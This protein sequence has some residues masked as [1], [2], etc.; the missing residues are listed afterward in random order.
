[1]RHPPFEGNGG[2]GVL[3]QVRQVL[4][5]Q[6][7]PG[8]VPISLQSQP[9]SV[10]NFSRF[11]DCFKTCYLIGCRQLPKNA[12]CSLGFQTRKEK[13][14]SK[15]RRAHL[16]QCTPR[17]ASVC[18]PSGFQLP[19]PTFPNKDPRR[20]FVESPWDRFTKTTSG[21]SEEIIPKVES[22]NLS[23]LHTGDS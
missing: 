3:M 14:A 10:D 18:C 19:K 12:G 9:L 15:K 7:S 5:S 6:N 21:E 1:M 20:C 2:G 4:S 13:V 17:D 16:C 22:T 8:R 11:I 23:V